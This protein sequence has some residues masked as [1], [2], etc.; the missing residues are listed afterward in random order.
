MATLADVMTRR[1]I[2]CIPTD[3]VVDAARIM[4]DEDCGI[5]PIVEDMTTMRLVGVVTDRDI[6]IRCVSQGRNPKECTVG[7]IGTERVHALPAGASLKEC[8]QLMESCQV[9]RV[10]VVDESEML[11]G[12]VSMADL[13]EE[14]D[15]AKLGHTLTE[16][17]E[18]DSRHLFSEV[19]EDKRSGGTMTSITDEKQR[20][21]A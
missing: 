13:A 20:R 16:I 5:V 19:N 12:I 17:S 2:C 1:P 11:I 21:V 4:R 15:D 9:R 7:E 18:P 8:R 6:V 10:P 14:L 3:N